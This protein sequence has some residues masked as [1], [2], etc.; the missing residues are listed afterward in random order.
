MVTE[1]LLSNL[2]ELCLLL[3]KRTVISILFVIIIHMYLRT[4]GK[5]LTYN[6]IG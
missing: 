3:M 2:N 1:N 6:D 5:Y 4:R